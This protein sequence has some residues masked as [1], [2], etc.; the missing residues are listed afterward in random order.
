MLTALLIRRSD[1]EQGNGP[2]LHLSV[3][4]TRLHGGVV[5]WVLHAGGGRCVCVGRGEERCGGRPGSTVEEASLFLEWEKE[6]LGVEG[7]KPC[8]GKGRRDP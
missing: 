1:A 5:C 4:D 3:S 6:T 7:R 8:R 2:F